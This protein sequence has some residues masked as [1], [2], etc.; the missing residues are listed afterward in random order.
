MY[1]FCYHPNTLAY[2]GGVPAE[3]DQLQPG[4]VLVPAWASKNA[5][6]S[7]DNAV[8]WPYYLPEKD[9]WEV[10][11]LPEPEPTPEAAAPAEPTKGEAIEAMQ[12]TLTAH[13]EAAQ[14]LM[15]QMKAAAGEGA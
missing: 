8:E 14:R 5:P 6:P 4:V 13:L 1:V 7:H 9:A 11:P 12:A 10:R 15:D 3:Y 2:T